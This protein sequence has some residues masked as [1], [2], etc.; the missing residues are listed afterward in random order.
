LVHVLAQN[1]AI[2]ANECDL[3]ATIACEVKK[4]AFLMQEYLG[5]DG[6]YIAKKTPF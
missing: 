3:T 1:P 5:M 6:A 4:H 2:F